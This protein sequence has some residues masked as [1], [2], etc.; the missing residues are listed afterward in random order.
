VTHD[1]RRRRRREG[2]E[3]RGKERCLSRI[4]VGG[5]KGVTAEVKAVRRVVSESGERERGEGG[6][7]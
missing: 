1:G 7:R 2:T 4:E 5:R 3:A 6:K